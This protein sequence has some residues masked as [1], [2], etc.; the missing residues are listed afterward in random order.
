M[1]LKIDG[2]SYDFDIEGM[3]N[4]DA[5]AVERVTGNTFGEWA[6]RLKAGSMEAVTALV[7]IIRR[8]SDPGL[9]FN[10]VEFPIASLSM[11]EDPDPKA[12]PAIP[13]S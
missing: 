11:D 3:S 5:I 12:A 9:K 13:S 2:T 8:Q 6:E 1:R 7:W 4:R 10:D